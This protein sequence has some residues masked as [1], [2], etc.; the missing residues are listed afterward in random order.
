MK[1]STDLCFQTCEFYHLWGI[2]KGGVVR[3]V[4][5]IKGTVMFRGITDVKSK[6]PQKSNIVQQD[7]KN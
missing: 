7:L 1:V 4:S 2:V 3:D 6:C 5:L